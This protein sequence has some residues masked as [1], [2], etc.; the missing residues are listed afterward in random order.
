MAADYFNEALLTAMLAASNDAGETPPPDP[1]GEDQT[2]ADTLRERLIALMDRADKNAVQ[3]GI[4]NDLVEAADFAACAF[5]DE[6]LL[7]SASWRGRPDWLK[8][9][10]QF[11]RHGTATAGE[12][13]YRILDALLESAGEKTPVALPLKAHAS[14]NAPTPEETGQRGPLHAVLEIFALCL[15]QGF[16]GMCYGNPEAVR[17]RLDKIGHFVP[18]VRHRAEPPFLAPA[19]KAEEQGLLRRAADMFRRFDTLD[20]ILWII[21]PV[22]TALLYRV[23]EMR[24]DQLLQPF[25]QGNAPS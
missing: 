13:F 16:T 5:I 1:D 11:A 2:R 17:E 23:C 19:G 8:T 4:P 18:A 10:L 21:P 14:G 3:A 24:L 12:D 20:W 15:A 25:L 9:P 7:S 6:T 22:L